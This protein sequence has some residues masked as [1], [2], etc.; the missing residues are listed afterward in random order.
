[1]LGSG[2]TRRC[3]RWRRSP[4]VKYLGFLFR[5]NLPLYR[6]DLGYISLA[7]GT[8]GILSQKEHCAQQTAD[9]LIK[10]PIPNYR[11]TETVLVWWDSVRR[12][13]GRGSPPPL[14]GSSSA[15]D[16]SE[17][18]M[19]EQNQAKSA[20]LAVSKL[21]GGGAQHTGSSALSARPAAERE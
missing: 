5:K 8:D 11:V 10:W 13:P 16:V 18:L 4:C 3:G 17:D 6:A 7:G 2:S 9:G 12:T 19:A 14:G 1:M 20:V 15:A 21:S